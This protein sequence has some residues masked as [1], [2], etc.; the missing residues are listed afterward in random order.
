MLTV[1]KKQIIYC[2]ILENFLALFVIDLL[3][4]LIFLLLIFITG[5]LGRDEWVLLIF[6]K[7]INSKSIISYQKVLIKIYIKMEKNV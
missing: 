5:L 4:A 2:L 3:R 1:L 7:K 6:I